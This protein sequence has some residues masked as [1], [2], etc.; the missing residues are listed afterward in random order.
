VILSVGDIVESAARG[1]PIELAP[2][3]KPSPIGGGMSYLL[4]PI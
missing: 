3:G 4:T 1:T 2:A